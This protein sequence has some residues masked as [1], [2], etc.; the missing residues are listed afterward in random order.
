MPA[1]SAKQ[2]RFMQAAAQGKTNKGV[3][4]SPETAKEF[5]EKT[6]KKKRSMFASEPQNKKNLNRITGARG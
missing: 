5:I 3:G 2:F 1:K 4:L 6:P